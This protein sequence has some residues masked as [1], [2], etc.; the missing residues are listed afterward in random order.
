MGSAV[1]DFSGSAEEYVDAT[2]GPSGMAA[3]KKYVE[4]NEFCNVRLSTFWSETPKLWFAQL[5]SEFHLYHIRADEAKYNAILRHL[6]QKVMKMVADVLD[7]PPKKD[8]YL[9]LKTVLI[10]RF[11]DSEEKQLHKL[12]TGI[13]LGNKKPS[14]LLREKRL[15]AGGEVADR[16]LRTLWMQRLPQ[17]IQEFLSVVE[18]TE[19]TKLADLADMATDREE[20]PGV[21]VIEPVAQQAEGTTQASINALTLLVN[22]ASELAVQTQKG[23]NVMLE[24]MSRTSNHYGRTRQRSHQRTG[25][26]K[27]SKSR[28]KY[29]F[30]HERFGVRAHKCVK[31][32]GDEQAQ[33]SRLK[34]MDR[35][36]GA[37]FLVDTGSD[38]SVIPKHMGRRKQHGTTFKL[39]TANGSPIDTFGTR[40]MTVNLGLRIS[41][42]WTFIIAN[43]SSPI[44]GAD[45][46]QHFGLLV[47][48]RNRR[49]LDA[50]TRLSASASPVKARISSVYIQS[51]VTIRTGNCCVS[52]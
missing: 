5:E 32:F 50:T 40:L 7:T 28:S 47:D 30:Y 10:N 18:G 11:T 46:L 24:A 20:G 16:L 41:F 15:L 12:L 8:K 13:E 23:T 25:F 43:V 22:Q 4:G 37:R 31:P 48:L 39:Y 14:E 9:N 52:T 2:P 36:S 51:T 49:L 17:R 42:R 29:C 26:R 1:D 3:V 35:E 6:D 33:Q 27:R 45:F 44:I 21:T 19:L 34:V 38:V